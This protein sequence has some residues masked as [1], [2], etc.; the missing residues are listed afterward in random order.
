MKMPES[1]GNEEEQGGA[2]GQRCAKG[3][4]VGQEDKGFGDAPTLVHIGP[5]VLRALL[6]NSTI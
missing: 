6:T 5:L 2:D 4:M 3:L 1:Q